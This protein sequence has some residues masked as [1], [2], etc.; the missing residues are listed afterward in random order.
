[1]NVVELLMIPEQTSEVFLK[2]NK[3]FKYL[4]METQQVEAEAVRFIQ[5]LRKE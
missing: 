4:L 3:G 1:M 5:S 2:R